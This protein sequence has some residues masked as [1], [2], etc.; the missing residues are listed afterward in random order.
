MRT[1]GKAARVFPPQV[2]RG[3]TVGIIAPGSP[4]SSELLEAGCKKLQSLGYRPF[5]FD[6][7]LD[8]D[9]YFAGGHKQRAR[10]LEQ[11]FLRPEIRAIVCARG[12]YGCNHLLPDID[13]DIIRKNPK[14]F[15]GYSDVTTLLTYFC[16]QADVVMYH[17]PM[18]T[19]DYAEAPEGSTPESLLLNNLVDGFEIS[20][21]EG[22]TQ[23]RS[24]HAEGVLY[25]GCLSL[26]VAS[27]GT[28]YE[29]R[30]EN[31]ILFLED[32][33]AKPYQIDR[34]MM[35]LKYAG[36]FKTVRGVIFG[37]MVGCVQPGGQDYTLQQMVSRVLSEMDVPI[38][39]GLPSGHISKPPNYCLPLGAEVS[40]EVSEEGFMLR[41]VNT[42]SS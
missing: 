34:M 41:S 35:Q 8:Q 32:I 12:G 42:A 10:E 9:H 31:A 29:I 2:R 28:P 23:P 21:G 27:L 22:Q 7:V 19:K 1:S 15:V 39:F 17:G 26:L 3:D 25:G 40:L 4:I 38:A 5:F 14:M 16:D 30:T 11:M 33:N 20:G 24:G 18:V 37:E 36:M 13:L 6:T